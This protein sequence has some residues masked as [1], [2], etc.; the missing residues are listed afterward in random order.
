M[1]S[2]LFI[3]L[4]DCSS[5]EPR[6]AAAAAGGAGRQAEREKAVP[7]RTHAAG[8]G[9]TVPCVHSKTLTVLP[10]PNE[11]SRTLPIPSKRILKLRLELAGLDE[12]H[13][14][15]AQEHGGSTSPRQRGSAWR[16]VLTKALRAGRTSPRDA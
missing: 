10:F 12:P 4:T 15:S 6:A 3:S 11:L 1:P 7:S 9:E 14:D 16:D 8:D 2:V 5:P 13:S